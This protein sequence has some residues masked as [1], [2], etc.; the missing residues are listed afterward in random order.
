MGVRGTLKTIYAETETDILVPFHDVDMM[1]VAWHG[2]Y[3]KYFEVARCELLDTLQ[4]GYNDMVQSGFAW[5]VID[6]AVRYVKPARFGQWISVHSAIVEYENRLKIDYIIRD[7]TTGEKLTKG[8]TVQVAVRV[9][10]H[11][12]QFESPAILAQRLG[13][14]QQ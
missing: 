2:H 6:L 14:S 1:M 4:Y 12:M 7:K 9:D 11:E 5:P 13:L 10:N 8:H 3:V